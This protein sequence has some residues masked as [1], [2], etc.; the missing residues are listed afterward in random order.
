ML[1]VKSDAV[2]IGSRGAGVGVAQAARL[3][4]S[5][6]MVVPINGSDYR[7]VVVPGPLLVRGETAASRVRHADRT[8]EVDDII[9]ASDRWRVAALA[10]AYA[11]RNSAREK[12]VPVRVMGVVD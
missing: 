10:V 1:S 12:F 4:R 5:P 2:A 11:W 6:Q 8:I 9:P 7:I 3:G